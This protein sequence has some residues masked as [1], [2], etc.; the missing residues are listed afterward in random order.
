MHQVKYGLFFDNHTQMENPDVGRDFD[1]EYFTDQLKSCGV[2]Y[3]GFHARCNVGMAYYDTAI[4]TPHPA[5]KYDLFG[6]LAE[7]CRK[8]GIALV[9]YI[10]GG[11]STMELVE[12]PEWRRL[13]FPGTDQFGKVAYG[14]YTVCYNSPFRAHLIAMIREIAAKYPVEG[15]FIDCVGNYPCVCARCVRRMKERGIDW[16]DLEAV[17]EFARL[18]ALDYCRDIAAAVREM[19]PDPMLYF[20][21]PAFGAARDLDTF[22]DCE[23]LPTGVYWGY[24]YLP[25]MAHFSRNIKPG[26]QVLNMTG[27]FYD[28]GD[29]G[30]LRT[31]ESLKFDLLYGLAHG[32][33]PNV[34][35]HLHP[36]GDRDEAVFDRIREVYA[37]LRQFD[38]WYE[39][40][41]NAADVAVV[42]PA[43]ENGRALSKNLAVRSCVRML[44]ELKLQFDIVFAEYE[45]PWDGYK[46]L[47]LP[48]SVEV[49]ETLARRIREHLA[50]GGALFA[51]GRIAA[52]KLSPE[53][54]VE[55]LGDSGF[56][57][58]YFRMHDEFAAGTP[59]MP[60][61]L[62]AQAAKARLVSARSAAP[63]VKPYYNLGWTGTHPILY[64]PPEAET[65]LPFLTVNGRCVWC[66]GDLF[67]GYRAHAALHLRDI[68]GNAVAEL[69]PEPLVKVVKLP[70]AVRMAVTEQPGRLNVHLLAYVP[71]KRAD[72]AVVEDPMA[73]LDGE[74]LMR[75]GK[76]H[77]VGAYLAPTRTQVSYSTEG[78]YTR[79][80][81]PAFEGY[82]LVVLEFGE[83]HK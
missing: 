10:N 29:F 59:D 11:L 64:T 56:D 13:P 78:A 20:N 49:T 37:D 4:G 57:P 66:S 53:L 38:Q 69:L 36:R 25:I 26:R 8:K 44:D 14:A 24:E 77:V 22:Y 75:T 33:R 41:R 58:V 52:E 70:A 39:G 28:W 61:S 72:T 9:A 47:I 30:G 27:R 74:F 67:T 60:L 3:L 12:H 68:F 17:R 15:F 16:S 32:M 19:L 45:K 55:Y 65:E 51:A 35:G 54:G 62:Y 50:R 2:D 21:G 81:L 40:A 34:G 48:E 73:V 63:L 76:Q 46:L 1:P 31:K 5:L 18:S 80:K 79:V 6:R 23:C 43:D 7:C 42:Y 82:A 83:P 71:E